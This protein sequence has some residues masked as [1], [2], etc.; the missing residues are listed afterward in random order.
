MTWMGTCGGGWGMCQGVGECG[1]V[2]GHVGGGV[3][4]RGS[5]LQ[6]EWGHVAGVGTYG[7]VWGYVAG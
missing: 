7:R 1:R 4:G 6:H 2:W 5:G 3:C